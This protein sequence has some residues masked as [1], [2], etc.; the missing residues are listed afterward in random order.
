MRKRVYI[1]ADYSINN[2][3]RE[4]VEELHQW[5]NDNLHKVDYVDT[6]QVVSGSVV[7]VPDCRACDLKYEFN[8][9]I[10]VSSAVIFIIGDKTASRLAGNLCRRIKEGE[11]CSC[12]PYKQNANGTTT[13]KIL[14]AIH[15][16]GPDEDLGS[17]NTFSYIEHEFKQA[18]KK[19]KTIIVVYNSL[20]RQPSWLPCYMKD[21]EKYAHPFWKINEKRQ[22]VGDYIFIKEA[23]DY[24]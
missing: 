16:P 23:L 10:N 22:K 21:Y 2:G 19:D 11:G 7:K 8:K 3:D 4:V 5:G 13:C 1:S 9:Q 17:I 18:K 6:A 14:G 15:T 12:T 24:E 20:N